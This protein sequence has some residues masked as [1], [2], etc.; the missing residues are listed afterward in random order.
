MRQRKMA[1]METHGISH[2]IARTL[3]I[4]RE[5]AQGKRLNLEVGTVAMGQ[6]MSIGF[7]HT[8][9][10]GDFISGL[11]TMDLCELNKLLNT[12]KIGMAIPDS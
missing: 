9:E 4:V 12:H 3:S 11:S 5:L 2:D 7:I 10:G 1:G 8:K 6:D